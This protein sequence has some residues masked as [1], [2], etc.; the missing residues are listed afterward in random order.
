MT[1]ADRFHAT[2]CFRQAQIHQGLGRDATP[3]EVA[4]TLPDP[5]GLL[6]MLAEMIVEEPSNG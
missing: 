1:P 4:L 2:A 5:H 6:G 3:T